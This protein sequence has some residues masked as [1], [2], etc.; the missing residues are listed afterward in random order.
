MIVNALSNHGEFEFDTET[1]L[2]VC[3]LYLDPSFG[4]KPVWV[5]VH[6]WRK[7]YPGESIDGDTDVL[8]LAFVDAK[9][10]YHEAEESWRLEREGRTFV[11][12]ECGS[13]DI[14]KETTKTSYWRG[15]SWRESMEDEE[16][17]CCDCDET[18]DEEHFEK[19][20]TP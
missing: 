15:G 11:C 3:T 13:T 16:F 17:S 8:D 18:G 9:G 12:P 10:A 1:G 2:V 5:D 20:E 19:K 14:R 7:R 6:E 4:P